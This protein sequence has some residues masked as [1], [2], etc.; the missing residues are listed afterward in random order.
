MFIVYFRHYILTNISSPAIMANIRPKVNF[1]YEQ[2][3]IQAGLSFPQATIYEILIKNG[4]LKAGR[5]A[6]K[7]PFKRGL[8]YKTLEDLEKYGLIEKSEEKQKVAIFKPK[9]P[10]ELKNYAEKREK[11]AREAKLALEGVLSSI[12]S[13]YNL[14][15]TKPGMLFYEGLEGVKTVLEDSLN[16]RTEILTYADMESV[17]KYMDKINKDYVK[18]RKKLDIKK[19]VIMPDSEFARNYMKTYHKDITDVRFIDYKLYSFT[20]LTEIYDGTVSY[21]TVEEKNK[22][23]VIIK[24]SEIYKMQKSLF[25]FI[26]NHAEKLV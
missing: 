13:D 4:S 11:Q 8:V 25:E 3:L 10:L 16:S 2:S 1:M 14:A 20:S 9:H 21:I 12:V 5:I 7:S 26:W 6:L 15:F 17:V 18:K 24:N 22:M 19:R 23:G